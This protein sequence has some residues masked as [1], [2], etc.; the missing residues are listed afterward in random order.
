MSNSA[1][2]ENKNANNDRYECIKCGF[3][4]IHDAEGCPARVKECF[5]CGKKG[6]YQRFCPDLRTTN[7]DGNVYAFRRNKYNRTDAYRRA[8]HARQLNE[9]CDGESDSNSEEDKKY[10]KQNRKVTVAGDYSNTTIRFPIRVCGTTISHVLDTGSDVNLINSLSFAKL[11]YRPKLITTYYRIVDYNKHS[12]NIL[13]EFCCSMV[14][15]GTKQL[16]RYLVVDSD[17]VDNIFG[18]KSLHDFDLVRFNL[19]TINKIT[20]ETIKTKDDFIESLKLNYPSL[21]EDR[22][23]CIPGVEIRIETDESYRPVQ[24]PAYPCP[25]ALVD[26]AKEAIKDMIKDDIIE[27]I[28]SGTNMSWIS[29]LHV[30]ENSSYNL[31]KT[32]QKHANRNEEPE[33]RS[34]DK[35]L[36]RITSNN[37]CLNKAIVKQKRL[38]PNVI[39]LRQQLH[40]MKFF[41]K[42]DIKSAFNT[43]MLDEQSRNLT[44]FITPWGKIY[45]YKRLNM[46]LCIASELFHERMCSLLGDLENVRPAIDD[47]LVMGST[48]EEHD[49]CLT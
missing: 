3:L 33:Q 15:N 38:M 26:G 49:K 41:S 37:K 16:A 14:I 10:Q 32:L 19:P 1:T 28:P 40:G 31:T 39:Q 22:V 18:N 30:V 2:I 23:G 4:G 36:I 7:I 42:V 47:I 9:V 44:A 25:F 27:E 46:G 35:K 5:K 48:I 20:T 8:K 6:H 24:Q 29:P 21:F 34:V 11:K 17:K 43:M 12:I 13:G 45:R